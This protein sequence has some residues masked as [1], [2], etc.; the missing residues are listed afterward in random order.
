[1]SWCKKKKKQTMIFKV[2]FEK[3]YD[4][5]RWDC[6]DVFMKK[7]GFDDAIFLGK[8]S[9][10]NITTIVNVLKCFHQAFGLRINLH[11]NKLMGIA[12][13]MNKVQRVANSMG[14]QTLKPPF[15]YLGVKVGGLFG[16]TVPPGDQV[17]EPCDGKPSRT[18]RRA[19]N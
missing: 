15:S 13:T 4:S 18:V 12:V 10:L 14:C 19:L 3:A 16:H 2:D 7:F 1:M 11:K 17:D 8:W 9:D 5:V 6:L